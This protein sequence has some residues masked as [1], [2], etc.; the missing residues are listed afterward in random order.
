MTDRTDRT[1]NLTANPTVDDARRFFAEEI[2]AVAH[3]ESRAL[4][5]AFAR[6]PREAFLGPGPWQIVRAFDIA[7]PY[8]RSADD[9]PRH[10]YHDVGVAI[11]PARMLNN[12]Q[13]SAL[14]RWIEAAAVAPGD[15]IL[16]IGCG[17]GYYTAILS[18]LT[19]AT[20]RVVACDVD[21]D[22]AARA[23]RNLALWPQVEVESSDAASPR[24]TFDVIF[25]NAGATRARPEWLGAL[26]PAGRMILPL[27]VHLPVYPQGIG[28]MLRIDRAEPGRAEPGRAGHAWPARVLSQVGIYDCAGA[29]DPAD[30]AE[31]MKLVGPGVASRIAAVSV[32]AHARGEACLVHMEGFCVQS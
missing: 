11:D 22:L 26:R 32:D 7:T 17:L 29:R 3:L 20:G 9:D 30:E 4:V 18:E 5:E 27:T 12:G 2:G 25:V 19:G 10:I 14:A 6:V 31:L 13:P 15:A 8:R 21:P 23:A 28:V 16:H 1:E 24:G